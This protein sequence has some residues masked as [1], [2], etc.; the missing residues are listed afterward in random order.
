MHFY[1][2][3]SSTNKTHKVLNQG[4]VGSKDCTKVCSH[5][6]SVTLFSNGSVT[7][8][9]GR[10]RLA[11]GFIWFVAGK[12]MSQSFGGIA[13]CLD[14]GILLN[15]VCFWCSCVSNMSLQENAMEY[16]SAQ[17]MSVLKTFASR[18]TKLLRL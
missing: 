6:R 4:N 16:F 17:G 18:A 8:V 1:H 3:N 13:V 15:C 11:F 9:V 5:V 12:C 2:L 7:S 10:N 14:S